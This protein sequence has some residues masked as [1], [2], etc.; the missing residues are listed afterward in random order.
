M[1]RVA[2]EL[3]SAKSPPR[4]DPDTPVPAV[5]V[6]HKQSAQRAEATETR[7]LYKR[8]DEYR[9]APP[10]THS[11]RTPITPHTPFTPEERGGGGGGGG[12]NFHTTAKGGRPSGSG[13]GREGAAG[14]GSGDCDAGEGGGGGGAGAGVSGGVSGVSVREAARGS[15]TAPPAIRMQYTPSQ[16][17][18]QRWRLWEAALEEKERQLRLR[19]A[20]IERRERAVRD[21]R[22]RV[23]V[24]YF[25]HLSLTAATLCYTHISMRRRAHTERRASRETAFQI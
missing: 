6:I 19:E 1:E 4:D 9:P 25:S 18:E 15:Q 22:A 23:Q 12:G 2:Q 7:R 20:E 24:G 16:S 5:A 21:A 14:A 13:S 17:D 8:G 3:A 10:N 11:P